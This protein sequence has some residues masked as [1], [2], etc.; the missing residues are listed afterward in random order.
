MKVKGQTPEKTTIK[1][2]IIRKDGTIEDLG[3]INAKFEKNNII[4]IIRRFTNGSNNNK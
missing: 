4:N 2:K 1:A 3:E